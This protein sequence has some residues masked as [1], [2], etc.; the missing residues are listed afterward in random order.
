MCPSRVAWGLC[1]SYNQC[2]SHLALL[3]LPSNNNL[4]LCN[5]RFSNCIAS[6]LAFPIG[7]RACSPHQNPLS[8]LPYRKKGFPTNLSQ[9]RAILQ[10]TKPLFRIH[11]SLLITLT[12]IHTIQYSL[13]IRSS[14]PNNHFWHSVAFAQFSFHSQQHVL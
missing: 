8:N 5:A 11:G 7:W 12:T 14:A 9:T 2:E 3:P 10:S 1:P 6:R 13:T 4:Q